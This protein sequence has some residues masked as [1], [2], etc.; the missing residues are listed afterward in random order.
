M[1]ANNLGYFGSTFKEEL[2]M[3]R[4]G[5]VLDLVLGNEAGQVYGALVSKLSMWA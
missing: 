4:E 2:V 1:L 5:L 3:V